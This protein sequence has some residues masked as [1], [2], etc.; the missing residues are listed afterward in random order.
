[1]SAT[2]AERVRGTLMDANIMLKATEE[3]A[4]TYRRAKTP[5]NNNFDNFHYTKLDRLPLTWNWTKYD[6]KVGP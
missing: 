6:Y 1:M 5:W 2:K 3:G 4:V